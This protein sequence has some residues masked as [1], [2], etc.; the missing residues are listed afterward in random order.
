MIFYF[1]GT[2]NSLYAA[3]KLLS[4]GEELINIAEAIESERYEYSLTESDNI[5]FVFPVY[6]YTLPTIVRDF[7]R[8]VSIK[9]AG[10]VYAVIT[11]GGG[12]S[13]AG[14]VLKKCLADREI[15]LDYVTPLLMPDNSMLFYQVPPTSE[16][17][18]RIE[19]ANGKLSAIAKDIQDR[20]QTKIGSAT[21]LSDMVGAGYKLCSKTA[22]FY[23]ED[24]C[25]GCGLCAK[26]CP[27]KAIQMQDGKPVWVKDTCCKCS[28]CI[29]RCPKEAIQY[30]KVTKKRNRYV[31][32]MINE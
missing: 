19:A 5:G 24:T 18:P 31:N 1:T 27:E 7:A 14:A 23:A 6:F 32:P 10:Y 25:V 26:N 29:C 2:G 3:K 17:G 22:K 16:A 21:I 8:K 20:K 9:G 28:A 13:Q 12:I 4:E 11:C 30:G 15:T